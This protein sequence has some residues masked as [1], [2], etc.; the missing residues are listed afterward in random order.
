MKSV[1]LLVA[2]VLGFAYAVPDCSTYCTAFLANCNSSVASGI[3]WYA[4]MTD[5]LAV[6]SNLPIGSDGDDF[7]NSVGCRTTF[8]N[9]A[10]STPAASCPAAS[11]HGGG[12]CGSYCEAYCTIGEGACTLANGWPLVGSPALMDQGIAGCVN[13]CSIYPQGEI[14]NDFG[15][16]TLACRLYHA[17]FAITS[18]LLV[19]CSHASP[20]GAGVCGTN[21]CDNYCQQMSVTCTGVNAQYPDLAACTSYC[22]NN[23]NAFPGQFNST[24]DDTL[25]CR[26]YHNSA[27]PTLGVVHCLHASPSGDDTCGSWCSVYCDLIQKNC[28]GSL[29][30]YPDATSCMSA[31]AAMNQSGNIADTAGDTVQCRIYHAGVAGNPSS[32]ANPH[33]LHAGPNGDG[34]CGGTATLGTSSSTTGSDATVAVASVF[35]VTILALVA[36]LV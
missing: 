26:L 34:V 28:A 3:N 9:D 14:G 19:H 24:G 17:Q 23:L 20:N 4:N 10:S 36:V 16:N 12:V 29:Q 13:I 5:C 11:S 32:N 2:I 25:G 7:G 21:T 8:A 22:T 35:L 6:C 15:N 18:G 30:Q 33:C 31:C 1:I 27:V